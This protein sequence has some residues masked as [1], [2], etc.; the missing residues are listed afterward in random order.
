VSIFTSYYNIAMAFYLGVVDGR[1]IRGVPQGV[2]GLKI[3]DN[4]VVSYDKIS[5]YSC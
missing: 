5:G 3:G 2:S 1:N 4:F